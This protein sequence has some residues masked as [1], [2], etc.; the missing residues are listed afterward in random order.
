MKR[1][2]TPLEVRQEVNRLYGSLLH[3]E[4]RNKLEDTYIA[5]MRYSIFFL[6]RF[7]KCKKEFLDGWE[8]PDYRTVLMIESKGRA[9]RAIRK[10]A[11]K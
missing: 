2:T 5:K 8:L 10:E 3:A 4:G 11:K 1:I 7:T 9:L 6:S